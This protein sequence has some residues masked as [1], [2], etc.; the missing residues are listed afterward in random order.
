MLDIPEIERK[1]RLEFLYNSYNA[2]SLVHPDPLEF[3]YD[4]PDVKDRE[5]VGLIASSLAYGRVNQILKSVE[6]VLTPMGSSPWMFVTS[7]N[8]DE[9]E[10]IYGDFKHR[11]TNLKELISI[12]SGVKRTLGKFESLDQAMSYSMVNTGT[13]LDGLSFFVDLLKGESK[14]SM[15]PSPSRGSA[16]K[17]LM[18][19]LRWMVRVDFVDPGGWSSLNRSDLIVPIDTHMHNI[20]RKLG[21]TN[22]KNGDMKTA[23][24]VTE[25]F[26][27]IAPEDPVKYDFALTRFGIR[28]DMNLED[29][30]DFYTEGRESVE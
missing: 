13:F 27:I 2:R 21:F 23:V 25:A 4:Y 16:C 24:E 3:L 1:R 7:G 9:W 10:S 28:S 12:L 22:R 19:Y 18:L 8:P 17:R 11:F 5:I 14:N 26:R 30:F 15:L 29:L 6:R 20:S